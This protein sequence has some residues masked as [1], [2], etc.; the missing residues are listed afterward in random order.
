MSAADSHAPV[1]LVTGASRGIGAHLADAFAEAGYVVERSSR[2]GRS[3]EDG[4]EVV[5]LDVVDEAAVRAYVEQIVERHGRID[6]LVNNAGVIDAEV[7]LWEADPAD[8]WHTVEVD[9]RG[10]FLMARAVVPHMIAAGSGRV[11]N[12]NS[13]SGTRS[14]DVSTA[15]YVAKSALGRITGGL[16]LAGFERGLRAFDLAPGVVRTDM[17]ESMGSHEG[18]TEWTD[19]RD[20]CDLAL[21]LASGELDAWSGRMVRA[22][23]DTPDSLRA[24]SDRLGER[25]R[26]VLLVPWGEDDP[27]A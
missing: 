1:V 21:A 18:R 4:A 13:G 16:H 26:Q 10:P 7:P 2:R 22:G 23:A 3:G 15:Y 12:L 17:T 20:V 19:P 5:A 27:L 14:N 6:V 9:V 24:A 11:V 25:A 8:W